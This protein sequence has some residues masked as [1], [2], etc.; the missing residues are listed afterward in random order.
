[1]EPL[2]KQTSPHDAE[3]SLRSEMTRKRLEALAAT[4]GDR[5]P[6][7]KIPGIVNTVIAKEVIGDYQIGICFIVGPALRWG[8]V[9]FQRYPPAP[10]ALLDGR[11]R[12]WVGH[13]EPSFVDIWPLS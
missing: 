1:M 3:S 4:R 10:N 7:K 13:N 8:E 11:Q 6:A 9:D 12:C 2:R 5:Q